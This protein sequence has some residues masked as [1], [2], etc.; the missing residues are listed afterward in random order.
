M[1]TYPFTEQKLAHLNLV[2]VSSSLL[3]E[4][5]LQT[6]RYRSF[7]L[8]SM[9]CNPT[10]ANESVVS[11]VVKGQGKL[12]TLQKS[13]ES[14]VEVQECYLTDDQAKLA[15]LLDMG[16]LRPEINNSAQQLAG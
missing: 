13:L 10:S 16:Q 7:Q 11:L 4:R 15:T 14:L 9:N 1:N 2:C 12:T 5:V 8:V 3:L 6:L